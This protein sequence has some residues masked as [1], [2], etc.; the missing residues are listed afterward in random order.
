M[1]DAELTSA[2]VASGSCGQLAGSCGQLARVPPRYIRTNTDLI[3]SFTASSGRRRCDALAGA[4]GVRSGASSA[5]TEVGPQISAAIPN[6]VRSPQE[7]D[8][9][10]PLGG[11][12]NSR[13]FLQ[14]SAAEEA[15]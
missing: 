1:A 13:C 2:V 10:G 8:V 9:V 5:D 12:P 11:A 4:I 3:C 7:T 15:Y 6:L 14:E